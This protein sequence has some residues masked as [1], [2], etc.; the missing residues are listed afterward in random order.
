MYNQSNGGRK[1]FIKSIFLGRGQSLK[2]KKKMK[3]EK[4]FELKNSFYY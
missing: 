3:K 1:S 2:M 4:H